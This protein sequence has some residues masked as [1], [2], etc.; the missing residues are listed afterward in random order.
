MTMNNK[1]IGY[2][3]L[4]FWMIGLFGSKL[5]VLDSFLEKSTLGS[6]FWGYVTSGFIMVLILRLLESQWEKK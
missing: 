2:S 4:V 1:F 6:Y 3:L 5:P